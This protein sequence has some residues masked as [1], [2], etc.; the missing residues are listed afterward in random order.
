M[1]KFKSLSAAFLL[2][3]LS[4]SLFSC[5]KEDYIVTDRK[6]KLTQEDYKNVF[7]K[8]HNKDQEEAKKNRAQR[9]PIPKLSQLLLTPP[10][11]QIGSD[12]TISFSVTDQVPLKDVLIELGRV[13]KIDVDIDPAI[14][15]GIILN[16]K[17][18]PLKEVIERIVVLGNLR[19]SYE[20]GVLKF[21]KD[22][23][24]LKNYFVDFLSGSQLWSDVESNLNA[25]LTAKTASSTASS[26][27]L[28]GGT[29]GATAASS[30]NT[31][32]SAGIITINA[33]K[34][35]HE[36]IAKYLND[37]Y[38]V[39]SAQ[40]LIEAKVVEVTLNDEYKAGIDWGWDDGTNSAIISSASYVSNPG[41]TVS[42]PDLLGIGRNIGA[43]IKALERFGTA[44][45]ISS[46]RVSA[47]NN[48]KASLDFSE[49]LIYFTVSSS[50]ATSSGTA[51]ATTVQT[52]T[53]T[54]NEV[55][56]GVQLS[57]TPSIN[58]I[59]KEITLDV[60]PKLSVDSGQVAI[61]PSVDAKGN[62][63]GNT[64]PIIRSREI[65]TIAKVKS[66]EI[67]VIGGLMTESTTNE[68]LGFPLLSKIPLLGNIFKY[69]DRSTDVVETVIFVKA[70][71][72]EDGSLGSYDRE[73]LDKFTTDRKN[74]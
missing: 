22:A 68:D 13:S 71:L 50:S 4:L 25:L 55:P 73:F 72:V 53:A 45:A 32:K 28:L 44:R 38:R 2:F 21:E 64:I 1:S 65:Q 41:L 27:N 30:I 67:L 66:G 46:P 63:L 31:N 10:P 70:T 48:Q 49:N 19:Y 61:D 3:C 9:A 42:T 36:E 51:T 74:F 29:S 58:L 16:A 33:T 40:V 12:K 26:D 17:D 8:D 59:T 14:S 18:R 20:N 57:I 39:A 7:F 35:Q 11:P 37:V 43:V 56:V 60:Q 5:N 69:T 34:A 54:K 52:V 24:Y 62:N 6:A 47:M 23:P 15:G